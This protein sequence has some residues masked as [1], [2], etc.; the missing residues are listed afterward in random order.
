MRFG[1]NDEALNGCTKIYIG[2]KSNCGYIRRNSKVKLSS[3][4]EYCISVS[5]GTVVIE[6]SD[7]N[8]VLYG[9]SDFYGKY[10]V[11]L[12]YVD[13]QNVYHEN[14]FEKDFP[15]F[16]LCSKPA[17]RSRGIWTWGHVIYDYRAFFDNMVRLKLNTVT[18]WNDCAPF[19]LCDIVEYAHSCG[20]KIIC[21]YSWFW[22]TDCSKI[23]PEAVESGIADIIKKYEEE[24]LPSGCDGIYFQSFTELNS[25]YI[26]D[27]L[28][29]E[30]VTDFVNKASAAMFGKYPELEL[31]FGLHANSVKEKLEYIKNVN[32]DVKIVWENCGAFPFHTL[33][34][35][36]EGFDSTMDFVEKIVNLRGENDNFGA[37]T[38]SIVQLRWSSFEH[39]TAPANIG[40][41]TKRSR[42]NRSLQKNSM[43]KYVQSFWL[44]H[45]EQCAEAVSFMSDAK[46][47]NLSLC[48][49]VEDGM[50]EEKIM[51]PV[52][53]YA[54]ILWNPHCD[55]KNCVR[56]VSLRNYVEFA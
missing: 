36:T 11:K 50:F 1:G 38:K 15:D 29:A 39:L 22:D 3:P 32:P 7:D 49:L 5:G 33:P 12:E 20:I 8:G 28:I 19:N 41:S 54:E 25:E 34:C 4:E 6:G 14:P 47:G 52:A 37:V 43:W 44:A 42:Q 31:W 16:E 40:V 23:N 17:V 2:T 30:A 45:P 10:I 55:I 13:D 48:A 46:S 35:H 9:C 18:I 53:L 24:Y 27:V 56:E 26:G 21:G 51:F